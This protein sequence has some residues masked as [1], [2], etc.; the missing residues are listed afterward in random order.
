MQFCMAAVMPAH[1]CIQK[2][3][4]SH[5]MADGH[6]VRP[7]IKRKR[8]MDR[9]SATLTAVMQIGLVLAVIGG[10]TAAILPALA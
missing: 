2:N 4:L 3:G 7:T 9:L 8:D 10:M 6:T 1:L 5:H